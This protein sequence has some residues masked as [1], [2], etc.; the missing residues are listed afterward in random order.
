MRFCLDNLAVEEDGE[1]PCDHVVEGQEADD[2]LDH[3]MA[4]LTN[5]FPHLTMSKVSRTSLE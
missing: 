3:Q 2:A 4:T 1:V 5:L